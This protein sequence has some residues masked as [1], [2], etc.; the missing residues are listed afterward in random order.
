M[1]PSA[2]SHSHILDRCIPEPNTG[3][4]FWVGYVDENGYG[5]C[6]LNGKPGY[7][8]RRSFESFRGPIPP[9]LTIDHLCRQRSCVNPDHMEAVSM[10]ENLLRGQS[11]SMIA[12]RTNVCARGH[13]LT[14]DNTVFDRRR[15]L[16]SCRQCRRESQKMYY[17]R[18]K[19]FE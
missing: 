1:N 9:G 8:H 18:R 12:H 14:P 3:C 5:R 11:P 2:T 4:W 17:R 19:M 15:N 7:A 6:F 16:R 13:P 10:R